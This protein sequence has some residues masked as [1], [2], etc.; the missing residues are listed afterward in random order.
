MS[1]VK[2]YEYRPY[3]GSCEVRDEAGRRVT[4]DMEFIS[5]PD[6]DTLL[7]HA[8]RLRREVGIRYVLPVDECD[9]AT[10]ELLRE[11]TY[12]EEGK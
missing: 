9:C 1:D 8:R 10:C 12:L 5:F 2:R 11:T 6:Y 3:T 4:T 7:A